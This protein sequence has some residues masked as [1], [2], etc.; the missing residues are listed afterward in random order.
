MRLTFVGPQFAAILAPRIL[1]WL[2]DFCKEYTIYNI[3]YTILPSTSQISAWTDKWK[4]FEAQKV[5][6]TNDR[7]L[8]LN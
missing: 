2:L 7:L 3:Q 8:N 4:S 6:S 5:K 1:K